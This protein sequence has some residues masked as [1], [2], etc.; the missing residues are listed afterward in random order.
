[1]TLYVIKGFLPEDP[2]VS[3]LTTRGSP[4]PPLQSPLNPLPFS[5][6]NISLYKLLELIIPSDGHCCYLHS[7]AFLHQADSLNYSQTALVCEACVNPKLLNPKLWLFPRTPGRTPAAN[8]PSSGGPVLSRY[9]CRRPSEVPM[10]SANVHVSS[11]LEPTC[12]N[13]TRI[14]T[15][16][17]YG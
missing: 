12:W 15:L 6:L 17:V 14:N 13:Y 10:P 8:F 7:C 1:M 4:S 11:P 5:S 9:G 2:A 16:D 3:P